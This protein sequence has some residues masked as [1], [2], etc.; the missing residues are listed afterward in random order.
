MVSS[1][2]SR[3][4]LRLCAVGSSRI[5]PPAPPGARCTI[6]SPHTG[7]DATAVPGASGTEIARSVRIDRRTWRATFQ[8]GPS[9]P[10]RRAEPFAERPM[11]KHSWLPLAGGRL[12]SPRRSPWAAGPPRATR[13]RRRS[14]PAAQAAQVAPHAP[15][16]SVASSS[17]PG[18]RADRIPPTATST[19]GSVNSS[20]GTSR[21]AQSRVRPGARRAARVALRRADRSRASASISI[22]WSIGSAPTRSRRW[23]KATGSPRSNTSRRRSTSCWPC[24]T[25]RP[26]ARRRRD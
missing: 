15:P 3:T 6:G 4:P 1:C 9:A 12:P 13:A 24:P 25:V 19:P 26:A 17:R 14:T 5:P 21:Q 10:A 18:P 20:S 22:A 16:A 7:G 8:R 23:P 11:V 2:L